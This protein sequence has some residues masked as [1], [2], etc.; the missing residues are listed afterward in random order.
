MKATGQDPRASPLFCGVVNMFLNGG[1]DQISMRKALAQNPNLL[2]T[3]LGLSFTLIFMLSYAVYANTIDT[4]YYTYTTE[5]T[6]TT[7]S[8]DDGM[9]FEREYDE[10][11]ST[12]T[13]SSNV[14]IDR[15]NL[16]WVN[17]TAQELAPGAT[18][19]VFDAAGLWTH[20]LLGVEDA[21][22]FSCSEDCQRN[23]STTLDEQDGDAVYHGLA[24]T[25]PGARSN[26]TVVAESQEQAEEM[27]AEIVNNRHGSAVLR[28]T[29]VEPGNRSTT[30][31]LT[32]EMVNEELGPVVPFTVDVASE[33]V[34]ALTAVFACFAIVLLPAFA[35]YAVS[36]RRERADEAK[37]A[38]A[39][40][41][42]VVES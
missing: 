22:D 39:E 35:I 34:W 1:D 25:E 15:N 40:A 21:T 28:V 24:V 11:D 16:T 30:P 36:R 31:T 4:A 10:E 41:A 38:E 26:G 12:T 20:S 9:T 27:A 13:W 18:L 19:T 6:T 3:L 17:V 42:D 23:E 5:A 7:Q 8:S 33:F 14:T 2:R 37:L 32:I 29:I